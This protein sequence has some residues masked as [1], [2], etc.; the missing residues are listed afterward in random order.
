[1]EK[2]EKMEKMERCA[3]DFAHWFV[4][5]LGLSESGP[6]KTK[7]QKLLFFSW[8][9]HFVNHKVSFFDDEL[10]ACADG[11]DV[12]DILHTDKLYIKETACK[13]YSGSGT[14]EYSDNE[15]ETLKLTCEIFKDASR[16]ELCEL[17]C[18]SPIWK[19]HYEE[20]KIYVN[21]EFDGA[22]DFKKQIMP[23][24]ELDIE[25]K[26]MRNLLYAYKHREAL[27]Y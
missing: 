14:S 17:S 6:D 5:N 2:L 1:M 13:N 7:L 15:I 26:M 24:N 10:R 9:I 3:P 20:S 18:Q 12:S 19:K 27:G 8:L 4:Q 21:G 22:Y 25:V 16:E 11:P 23:K